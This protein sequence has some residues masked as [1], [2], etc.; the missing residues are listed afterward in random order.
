MIAAA[1]SILAA[2]GILVAAAFQPK[3]F[4]IERSVETDASVQ[5]IYAILSDLNQYPKWSPWQERDPGLQQVIEVHP[6]VVGSKLSWEGNRE[7][8]AGRLT[9]TEAEAN[10]EI[11]LRLEF[12]RP[13]ATTNRARWTIERL[14]DKRRITWSMDGVNEGLMPRVFGMFMDMDAV[15]GRDFEKGLETLKTLAEG[16]ARLTA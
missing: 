4:H 5:D 13:F 16:S 9:I 12:F 14:E 10:Q 7:V 8:G 11:V 2:G 1:G 15:V 3:E 6:G